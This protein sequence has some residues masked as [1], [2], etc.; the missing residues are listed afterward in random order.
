MLWGHRFEQLIR[1]KKET[2]EYRVDYS[3]FNNTYEV[4][5]PQYSAKELYEY[6]RYL[7]QNSPLPRISPSD[8]F[9]KND[10]KNSC[11]SGV[12]NNVQNSLTVRSLGSNRHPSSRSGADT[13]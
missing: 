5:T 9:S 6:Q 13:E 11:D 3:K 12:S 2:G 10:D 4:D 7:A 8:F 1:Y